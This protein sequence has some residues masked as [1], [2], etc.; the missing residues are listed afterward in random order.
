MVEVVVEFFKQYLGPKM[1]VFIISILPVLELR[2]GLV[3]ARLL[4]LP[5]YQAGPIAVLGTMLPVPFIIFFI[6]KILDFLSLHGPIKGLAK[7]IVKEGREG[8]EK[9]KKKYP[10]S[11]NIGLLLFAAIPFPG[12]G[13]WTGALIAALLGMSPKKSLPAIFAGTVIAAALM[14][15]LAY[16]MPGLLIK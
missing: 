15:I 5:W 2:G 4:D 12:F 3:A 13:A 14:L 1:M 6:E 9:L 7:K 11:L 10:N 16:L 8:G